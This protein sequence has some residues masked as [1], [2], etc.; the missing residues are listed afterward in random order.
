MPAPR[1]QEK[2]PRPAPPSD[3]Q[4]TGQNEKRNSARKVSADAVKLVDE[5]DAI[6]EESEVAKKFLQQS[7]Q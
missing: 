6:L 1:E 3:G 2:K 7:G 4:G 5:L